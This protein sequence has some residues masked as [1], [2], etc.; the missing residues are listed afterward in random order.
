MRTLL[1]VAWEFVMETPVRGE[2]L[3]SELEGFPQLVLHAHQ[4]SS[5]EH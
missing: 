1:N 5:P 2:S 4:T 3:L